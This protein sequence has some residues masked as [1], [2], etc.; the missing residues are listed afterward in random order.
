MRAVDRYIHPRFNPRTREACD[1]IN[2]STPYRRRRFQST[3]ARSVRPFSFGVNSTDN[4]FQSTH[5]RSVRP[6]RFNIS[7]F[8]FQFQSTHARSV[9]RMKCRNCTRYLRFNP[10]TREACDV[11]CLFFLFRVISFNPRTREACDLR[12]I[13]CCSSSCISFNPRTREACD[14]LVLS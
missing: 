6:S 10:R 14:R 3:H 8:E 7:H 4:L 2:M 5:A 12:S 9:R 11:L 1:L 13:I